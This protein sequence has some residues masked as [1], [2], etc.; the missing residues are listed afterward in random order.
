MGQKDKFSTLD[1]AI[2]LAEFAHRHAQDQAGMPYIDH[3]KRVLAAV[4]AQGAMPYV[5]IAAILHDVTE[6]TTYTCDTLEALGFPTAATE[7]IRLVDREHSE[8]LFNQFVISKG[9]WTEDKDEYYYT[10]I[11]KNPG[12]LQVKLADIGDN[13]QPWRLSYLSTERQ[14]YLRN[15]YAKALLILARND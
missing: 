10:M 15:K 2:A 3:P 13:T 7:I 14:N 4:Q 9:H 12:A 5:Q 6:D 8:H 11:R 1:D